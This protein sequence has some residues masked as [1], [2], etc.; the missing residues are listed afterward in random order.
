MSRKAETRKIRWN[1]FHCGRKKKRGRT[2]APR[3]AFAESEKYDYS[4]YPLIKKK[5]DVAYARDV[6][7]EV[8]EQMCNERPVETIAA[9]WMS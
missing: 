2:A 6:N 5:P 8:L 9:E 4:F 7:N 3:R 1:A